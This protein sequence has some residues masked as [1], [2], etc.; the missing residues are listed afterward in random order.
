[1]GDISAMVLPM[2]NHHRLRVCLNA[3]IFTGCL[4]MAF[5]GHYPPA[6]AQQRPTDDTQ[7]Y[8]DIDG[9]NHHLENTDTS[10]LNNNN[11]LWAEVRKIDEDVAGF[12][13]EER[14]WGAGL[15]LLTLLSIVM[16]FFRTRDEKRTKSTP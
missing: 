5:S 9:I 13:G 7:F 4:A 1:M 16:P 12:K 11:Q 8:R 2:R 6:A 15:S 10:V 14:G 3:A